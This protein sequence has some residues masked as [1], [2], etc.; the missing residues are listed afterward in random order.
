MS[1]ITSDVLTRDEREKAFRMSVVNLTANKF[2]D[3][4]VSPSMAL[5]YA[6]DFYGLLMELSIPREGYSTTLLANG[7]RSSDAYTGEKSTIKTIDY[8]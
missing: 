8:R 6:G 5:K 3:V 4:E 1:L 2:V 7:L